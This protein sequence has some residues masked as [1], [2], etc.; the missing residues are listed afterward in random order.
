MSAFETFSSRWFSIRN[1]FLDFLFPPRCV[2]CGRVGAWLCADCLAQ[3]PRVKPPFCTRC[4]DAVTAPGLCARCQVAPLEI[5]RIRSAVYFKGTLRQ[6]MHWLKYRGRTVLAVPLGGLMAEYW[7]QHPTPADVLVPVPLHTDRLRARG[8]NQA[9]LLARE[10]ARRVGL[11]V[12]EQTLVRCRSTSSQVKLNAQQRK[13]N[14]HGAFTC[15]GDGL[16]GKQV[17]LID[18]VCTTG[19]TLEACAIALRAGGARQVQALTLA[20]AL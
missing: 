11:M 8:Y 5:D 9:A 10:M 18:D 1:Q 16:A 3:I 2:G 13:Q 14:V 17:L 6:A 12:E 20:R 19:A 15:S 7:K 4:G